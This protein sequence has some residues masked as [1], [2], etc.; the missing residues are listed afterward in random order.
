[1]LH[2]ARDRV[3]QWVHTNEDTSLT[4]FGRAFIHYTPKLASEFAGELQRAAGGVSFVAL[5]G[6]IFER[7]SSAAALS[8]ND[9]DELIGSLVP[10]EFP[11][12]I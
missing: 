7:G 4:L 2:S 10:S 5:S 6:V 8:Q 12:W 9:L 1:M 11:R 3:V